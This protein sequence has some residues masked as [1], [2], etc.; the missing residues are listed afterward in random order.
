[1]TATG[2]PVS[3]TQL[4][5]IAYGLV[6]ETGQ[7]PEDYR[8]WR[9]QDYKSWTTLQSHF[10]EA[11]ADLIEREKTSLQGGYVPNNLVGINKAF[12]KPAQAR[13][14]D[15]AA[16]TNLADANI[17]LATQM[18]AQANKM[19]TKDSAMETMSKLIQQLQG[20]IKTLKSKQ[21]GQSTKKP[22]SSSY[23]KVNGGAT[24][25]AGPMG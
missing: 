13:L 5:C 16:V 21:A 7:Y 17:H 24:N 22:N 12:A 25:T 1:M 20:E 6:A 11:Q 3:E 23:K 8:A 4:V 19:V 15:R 9:N 18:A 14:E 2:K 10:I